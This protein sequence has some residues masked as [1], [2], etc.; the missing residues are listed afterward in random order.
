MRTRFRSQDDEWVA[1][2]SIITSPDNLKIIQKIIEEEGPII[3]QHWFYRGASAP[4]YNVFDDYETLLN[5]LDK[6]AYAGDA[7]DVWS[8]FQICKPEDRR[9]EG[10]CPD[11][12]G[13]IPRKGAY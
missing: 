10:K 13:L 6:E 7:I 11:D 9:V 1:E 5:Y 8:V 2:G 12:N 3:V 4:E